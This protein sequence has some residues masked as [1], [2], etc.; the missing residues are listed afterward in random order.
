VLLHLHKQFLVVTINTNLSQVIQRWH[1]KL[2]VQV[3]ATDPQTCQPQQ[4]IV[5]FL[6]YS[7]GAITIN[8]VDSQ[9]EGRS[10][11]IENGD[12]FHQEVQQ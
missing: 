10:G 11:Q 8:Q 4:L 1:L 9:W 6:H 7:G 12:N 3:L 5:L 2:G